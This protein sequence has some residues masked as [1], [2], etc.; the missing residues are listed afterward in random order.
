MRRIILGCAAAFAGF[1]PAQAASSSLFQKLALETA[2]APGR[3]PEFADSLSGGPDFWEVTGLGARDALSLRRAPSP[4]APL[5]ARFAKGTVLR[6]LGC[7][8]SGGGRW[9]Q[10]EQPDD[11]AVRGWVNGRYLRESAGPN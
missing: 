10:V 11:P 2:I 6:N 9:C 1:F 4:H 5:M 7:R 3:G 8:I